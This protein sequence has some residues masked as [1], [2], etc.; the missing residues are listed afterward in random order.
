MCWCEQFACFV[1]TL[2]RRF[3]E[4]ALSVHSFR[5]SARAAVIVIVMA[6]SGDAKVDDDGRREAKDTRTSRAQGQEQRGR[7]AQGNETR[8]RRNQWGEDS[9]A[10]I[11]QRMSLQRCGLQ[12]I[13]TVED[14]RL[15]HSLEWV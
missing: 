13:E 9:D 5:P 1:E 14:D 15:N 12:T 7:Q 4:R 3:V 8:K 10:T 11:R 2:P 6:V